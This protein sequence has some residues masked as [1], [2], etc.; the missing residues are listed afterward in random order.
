MLII[1]TRFLN[2]QVSD[3]T[4]LLPSVTVVYE[5]NEAELLW[6]QLSEYWPLYQKQC[7]ESAKLYSRQSTSA[8]EVVFEQV[9]NIYLNK[10]LYFQEVIAFKD[11]DWP[12]ADFGNNVD[13]QA[14]FSF[15]GDY[16]F[17]QGVDQGTFSKYPYSKFE[18]QCIEPLN[19][20]VDVEYAPSP[21]AGI[22]D[23]NAWSHYTFELVARWES[24]SSEHATLFFTPRKN[25][26]GW[27]GQVE[28]D[29]RNFRI[30]QFEGAIGNMEILQQFS[31][32][33]L[34]YIH[35]QKL[36][37]ANGSQQ[38]EYWLTE[39]NRIPSM[40]DKPRNLV[41]IIPDQQLQ[42]TDFWAQYRPEDD[43]L[44]AWTARQDSI[45]RYL[46]SDEYL[47][48]ADAV[49]N[50]FHWYEPLV[51]GVGYRK[52]SAGTHFFYSPL[53]G[54]F[55]AFGVG[56]W[57]WTPFAFG[58]KRFEND[59]M[60]SITGRLNYG[61]TN[62]DTKGTLGATYTY[63]PLRNASWTVNVG[64]DY[65]QITQSVDLT[66]LFAR[67][68]FIEK[69]FTE[70]YHRYEWFN[71]FYTRL[72]F[73][74]SKRESI[75]NLDLGNDIFG[76]LTPPQPF[77]TYTV[78]QVSAEILI[79]PYQR[80][81]LKGKRKI[82]L[83]S[84]WPDFRV[85][86]KQGIP[87]LLNSDVRYS[88][89]EFIVEDYVPSN[90]LGFSHYRVASG[91]FLNDPSTVRFIEYKWFRGGDYLL[92]THPLYTFQNLPETFATPEVY[93]MAN[94]THHF[95][96]FLLNRVP[97]IRRLKLNMALGAS[98]LTIPSRSLMHLE[99]YVGAE[100]KMKL[101]DQPVR[102]GMYYGLLPNDMDPGYRIKIGMD[103]K[104]TFLD[105]WNF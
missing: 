7:I 90:R 41:A 87:N 79:R 26:T 27:V 44:D 11:Y 68:N 52:R 55:N 95:E 47:D 34:F 84:K 80:Y 72:G 101:W 59:Q 51:S 13:I 20:M 6:R 67:S 29:T 5:E 62:T 50:E 22:M 8:N 105:R 83:S 19:R 63:A 25:R 31:S 2:A 18:N 36:S 45:I 78:G 66:G 91:G 94:A 14:S 56:G 103:F 57:R 82:V 21:I 48:S 86:F 12:V 9:S 81:Y 39:V 76:S 49:Y 100:R 75:E 89:Y 4:V 43:K 97:L 16:D 33:E 40:S 70:V 104:D 88:K 93:F 98:M 15:D 92:Y 24:D 17:S 60:L 35:H 99:T 28:V 71:G 10:D 42:G 74:Y 61:L 38:V 102:W 32:T 64:N 46:N 85:V 30:H 1:L 37:W 69:T 77:E 3:T 73:E 58:T 23:L 54:Q 65:Q 96:G 53:I